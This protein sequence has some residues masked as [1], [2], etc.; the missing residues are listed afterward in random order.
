MSQVDVRDQ[1]AINAPKAEV[2]EAIKDPVVHTRWHP[3]TTKIEGLHE[4][5]ATRKCDVIAG[6]KRG[7]TEERCSTFEEGKKIL[8]RIE[9]D[10]TGFSKMV[11]DWETGFSLESRGPESTLVEAQSTFEPRGLLVRLT[12]PLVKKKFHDTQQKIL[13]GLKQFVEES[14]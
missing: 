11:S 6:K 2:W 13:G 14:R 7:V 4:R 3:F 10:T 12:A 8:W 9:K 1:L 5:G